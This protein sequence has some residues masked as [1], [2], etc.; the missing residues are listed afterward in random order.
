MS[1]IDIKVD[2]FRGA[3]KKLDDIKCT[4]E[5][6]LNDIYSLSCRIRDFLSIEIP[7]ESKNLLSQCKLMQGRVNEFKERVSLEKDILDASKFLL[8]SKK[9]ATEIYRIGLQVKLGQANK[10]LT[11]IREK[12]IKA[13]ERFDS[14]K[15]MSDEIQ[16]IDQGHLQLSVE[17]S[18]EKRQL[19]LKIFQNKIREKLTSEESV[20]QKTKDFNKVK[21]DYEVLLGVLKTQKA[22][23]AVHG[24]SNFKSGSRIE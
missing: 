6:K 3:L 7:I 1:V 16:A 22:P 11:Y 5:S 9:E 20:A 12:S 23:I 24:K 17:A 15:L 13:N 10:W 18:F 2:E 4:T 8:S 21:K 19:T 14:A